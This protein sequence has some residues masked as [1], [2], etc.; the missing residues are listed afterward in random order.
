M[1]VVWERKERGILLTSRANE[2]RVANV[3]DSARHYYDSD[4]SGAVCQYA[5]LVNIFLI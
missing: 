1:C 3:I 4:R 5:N 2:Q